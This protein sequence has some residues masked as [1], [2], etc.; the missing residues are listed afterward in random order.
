[1]RNGADSKVANE[2][3]QAGI[4][5]SSA[6]QAAA[7]NIAL[8]ELIGHCAV[9]NRVERARYRSA[10]INSVDYLYV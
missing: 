9:I 6:M 5:S 1:M 2:K 3:Y 7:L 8:A 10:V 4:I